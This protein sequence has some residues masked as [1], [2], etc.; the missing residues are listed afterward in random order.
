ME[1]GVTDLNAFISL[2]SS[3]IFNGFWEVNYDCCCV[4]GKDLEIELEQG[5]KRINLV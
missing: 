4:A 3:D 2:G 5:T 1:S